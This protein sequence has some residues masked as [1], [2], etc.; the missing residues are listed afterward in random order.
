MP[1]IPNQNTGLATFVFEGVSVPF[2]AVC[3]I[4]FE[5]S[6]IPVQQQHAD[7]L[8]TH[9]G[10]MHAALSAAGCFLARV[11]VKAGPNETGGT[12]EAVSGTQGASG[13][14]PAPPNVC[15]L[16]R[17]QSA[18]GGRRGRGRMFWPCIE[19]ATVNHAGDVVAGDVAIRQGIVDNFYDAMLAD[20]M[21]PVIL[22][23]TAA[24]SPTDITALVYDS[25]VA[26]QRDRLRR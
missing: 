21:Q 8:A 24:V 10:V 9:A 11:E 1:V 19:E 7:D 23:D 3:T 22:H 13:N 6:L 16:I 26:T 15:H 18:L 25:R 12:W 17:K 14:N 4:G 20:G 2:G 5:S